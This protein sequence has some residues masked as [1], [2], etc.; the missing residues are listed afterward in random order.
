MP[1]KKKKF[2]NWLDYESD[3]FDRPSLLDR[4]SSKSKHQEKMSLHLL[5]VMHALCE[6]YKIDM[7][8]EDYAVGLSV[9]LAKDFVPAMRFR[10]KSG[11]SKKWGHFELLHLLAIVTR[12]ENEQNPEHPKASVYDQRLIDAVKDSSLSDLVSEE[13]TAKTLQNKLVNFRNSKEYKLFNKIAFLQ[14]RTIEQLA[15]DTFQ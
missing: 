9:A 6:H 12:L 10:K 3:A 1:S 14:N 4:D 11:A 8:K 7:S 5:S 2:G 13:I 15:I